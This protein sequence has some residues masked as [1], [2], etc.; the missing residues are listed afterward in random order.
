MKEVEHCVPE[1][2]PDY[3]AGFARPEGRVVVEDFAQDIA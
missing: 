3:N 1:T 2:R